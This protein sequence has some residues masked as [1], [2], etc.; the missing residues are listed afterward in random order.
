M[1]YSKTSELPTSVKKVLPT[2]AQHIYREAFNSAYD[3]YKDPS[4]RQGDTGREEAAHRVA[5]SA[6]KNKYHKG[7]DNKWHPN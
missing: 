4:K 7:A 3:E 5:W 2:H 1:P 6:V